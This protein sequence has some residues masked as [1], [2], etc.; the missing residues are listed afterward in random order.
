M[1]FKIAQPSYIDNKLYAEDTTLDMKSDEHRN[2][3]HVP[4]PHWEPLDDEAKALCKQHGVEY[5]GFVPDSM[6][7]LVES[8]EQAKQK[9][10]IEDNNAIGRGVANALI[11]AG[12]VTLK[13]PGKKPAANEPA[14]I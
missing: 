13:A 7:V 1:K 5:T 14:E 11:E 10:A 2:H 4:G 6:D 12:V 9:K 3:N 8:L